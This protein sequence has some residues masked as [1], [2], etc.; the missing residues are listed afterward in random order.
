[1]VDI[2]WHAPA[3]L[4]N[5]RSIDFYSIAYVTY[6]FVQTSAGPNIT[7]VVLISMP[8]EERQKAQS[9]LYHVSPKPSVEDGTLGAFRASFLI[10]IA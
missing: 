3:I 4:P 9:P 6:P 8:M 2:L 7:N 5:L 10:Q 1:M